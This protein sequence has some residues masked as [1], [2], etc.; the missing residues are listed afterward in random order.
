[1]LYPLVSG[2][3]H[4]P[5]DHHFPWF[6]RTEGSKKDP[7]TRLTASRAF[8]SLLSLSLSLHSLSLSPLSLSFPLPTLPQSLPPSL[9]CPSLRPQIPP[10]LPSL[11]YSLNPPLRPLSLSQCRWRALSPT[12]PA[13]RCSGW[14][15]PSES[16]ASSTASSP[17]GHCFVR[18]CARVR[19]RRVSPVKAKEDGRS[20]GPSGP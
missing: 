3:P 18:V 4:L 13:S 9:P 15:A 11:T 6:A 20:E 14:P 7:F 19:V 16:S 17:S 12:C 8:F 5:Q 10:I 2:A 1:M